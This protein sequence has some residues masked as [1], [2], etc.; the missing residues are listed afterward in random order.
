MGLRGATDDD[1]TMR[2][3]RHISYWGEPEEAPRS[4]EEDLVVIPG[5]SDPGL[6][7]FG[8]RV[9]WSRLYGDGGEYCGESPP[10][11]AGWDAFSVALGQRMRKRKRD[12]PERAIRDGLF[13]AE[14]LRHMTPLERFLGPERRCE[15]TGDGPRDERTEAR[16][17]FTWDRRFHPR[18]ATEGWHG[19]RCIICGHASCYGSD[20]WSRGVYTNGVPDFCC[21]CGWRLAV[22]DICSRSCEALR[23]R[24]VERLADTD[25]RGFYLRGNEWPSGEWTFATFSGDHL[26]DPVLAITLNLVRVGGRGLTGRSVS[27]PLL[28]SRDATL[29]LSLTAHLDGAAAVLLDG[30]RLDLRRTPREL[31]LEGGDELDLCMPQT[32]GGVGEVARALRFHPYQGVA[33]LGGYARTALGGGPAVVGARLPLTPWVFEPRGSSSPGPMAKAGAAAPSVRSAPTETRQVRLATT[34]YWAGAAQPV[35][36]EATFARTQTQGLANSLIDLLRRD[37]SA[38]AIPQSRLW[39]VADLE[40]DIQG[41]AADGRAYGTRRQQ[42]S[43]WKHWEAWCSH[44][45]INPWRFDTAANAGVD[46]AGAK[47]EAFILGAGLRFIFNRMQPRRRSDPTPLPQ[48]ALNVLLGVRRLHKDRGFPMVPMPMIQGILKGMMRRVQ[49]EYG[50]DHPNVL[51]PKRKE[52]FTTEILDAIGALPGDTRVPM[53]GRRNLCWGDVFGRALWAMLC[54]LCAAGLRKS[55]VARTEG[56]PEAA[57]RHRRPIAMRRNA[58]YRIGGRELACPTAEDF[59]AMGPGDNVIITPPPSKA[60]QWAMVWGASPIYLAWG[61]EPRNACRALAAMELGDMVTGEERSR[62]PLFSPGGGV[63][64][65]GYALDTALRAMLRRVVP[66]AQVEQ[67]SWHS[68]RIYLACSLLDAGASNGQIQAMCRWL[69]EESLH[70]YA[71]MNETTYTYWLQR[72]LTANV[73]SVRATSLAAR[74]PLIED[75]QIVGELLRLNLDH[76]S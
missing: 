67:Y 12:Q 20:V 7:A 15:E 53:P 48:S 35:G 29:E 72:A 27:G 55:E 23:A 56:S 31:G 9:A 58:I 49:E 30:S 32:G 51:V 54:V 47:R 45:G 33:A 3:E 60:D 17:H 68:A 61:P 40:I 66:A 26:D 38:Y 34:P 19:L 10:L 63:A 21:Q 16:H 73:N 13:H 1:I 39:V 18:A 42:R 14:L 75:A 44:L 28:V 64:F 62:T 65:T 57:T 5:P 8:A 43:N 59:R 4:A 36:V 74:C 52:P 69:S 46:A 2:L 37:E 71:R 24:C 6:C 41:L 50:E 70:I 76:E 22:V 25:R 11:G